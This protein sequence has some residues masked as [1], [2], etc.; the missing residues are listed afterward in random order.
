MSG[1]YTVDMTTTISAVSD[2]ARFAIRLRHLYWMGL[3]IGTVLVVAIAV[4][5]FA[6]PPIAHFPHATLCF[7]GAD[8]R[9][10]ASCGLQ[11]P[12]SPHV[13]DALS[14]SMQAKSCKF[15]DKAKGKSIQ[16]E[17]RLLRSNET[18]D[19]YEFKIM[20][21]SN[22]IPTVKRISI[23]NE[24]VELLRA[25]DVLVRIIEKHFD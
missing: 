25:E 23:S 18:G 6:E 20:T 8:G 2:S 15:V 9:E 1:Q 22:V 12:Q 19:A 17:W 10:F 11:D 7:S 16:I 13:S 21:G 5:Q 3:I 24:P 14:I 4:I